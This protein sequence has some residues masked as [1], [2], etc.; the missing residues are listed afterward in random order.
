MTNRDV[1][2]KEVWVKDYLSKSNL[3]ACDFVINPYVGCLHGCEY[4]YAS[5][6]KRFTGHEEPWGEFIDIKR[7]DKEIDLEKIRGKKVFLSSVT[8]CYNPIERE[9]EITRGILQQLV[10]AD[11]E[12]N[13]ATKSQLILRDLDLLKKMKNLSVAI[14]LNTLD[15]EFRGQ[16]EGF[17]SVEERIE[18]LR[19]LHENGIYSILFL[20]PIFPY[21]VDFQK[22][23][24]Q[25]K[26]F[27]DEYWF[28]NL[29]LRGA[30]K[31]TILDYI[32]RRHGH[33]YNKYVDIYLNNDG[34]YWNSLSSEIENFCRLNGI[35]FKNF[36]YHEKLVGKKREGK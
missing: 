33:L 3:P 29:N 35:K 26:D 9:Y 18:T 13:I 4:C 8:D 36:F 1:K 24:M 31:R 5:F 19:K 6:M 15:D 11:C 10:R 20:S 34:R 17:G 32:K 2:I 12:L 28:E 16:L 23:I 30:Y 7:C 21:L 14:S 27:V 25:V 22:I